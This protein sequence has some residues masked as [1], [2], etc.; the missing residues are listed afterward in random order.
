MEIGLAQNPP[1]VDDPAAG[2]AVDTLV[3][4]AHQAHRLGIPSLWMGQLFSHDAVTLAA[5]VGRERANAAAMSG[6]VH[7]VADRTS[8]ARP[9]TGVTRKGD[10]TWRSYASSTTA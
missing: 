10:A 1:S 8:V 3:E 5:L 4:S 7:E 9:A 6:D 2:N